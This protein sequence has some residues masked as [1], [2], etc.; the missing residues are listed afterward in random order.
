MFEEYPWLCSPIKDAF[1]CPPT[2]ADNI[3]SDSEAD[4]AQSYTTEA[5]GTYG[6]KFT[7]Y[8]VSLDTNR[9]KLY[10]E[11]PL[12]K[13][14]RA[15]YFNGYT[16]SIP[17]NVLT[18]QLQGI[19][20]EDL[21]TVQV[22]RAAFQFWSTYGGADRNTPHTYESFEPRIGDVVYLEP[23]K[24]FY[25]IMDVKYYQNA[26][27]LK[28]QTYTL[29]LKVYKDCKYSIMTDNETLAYPDPIYDVAPSG[30]PAQYNTKDPLMLNPELKNLKESRNV[31]MMDPRHPNDA[32]SKTFNPLYEP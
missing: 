18:Y 3:V 29:S 4:N 17:P 32:V 13:I 7:Y 28:S 30:L 9:D 5:Y 31:N 1:E 19:W 11:D 27:G 24:T 12:Q 23:N 2:K 14:E 6:L 10:G 25:E 20:G 8:K 15:F 22:G 16:E 21:V 26:F